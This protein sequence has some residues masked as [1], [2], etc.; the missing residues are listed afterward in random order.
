MALTPQQ[1]MGVQAILYLG[2][3]S[4]SSWVDVEGYANLAHRCE[5]HREEREG[6]K[7]AVNR[8]R[9]AAAV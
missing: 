8:A 1:G 5:A 4:R 6:V 2:R 7:L 3:I 9:L